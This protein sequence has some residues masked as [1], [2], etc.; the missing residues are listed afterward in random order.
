MD[1]EDNEYGENPVDDMTE[2]YDYHVN[3]HELPE[4]FDD[5]S[6]DDFIANLNDWDWLF[7]K[8][9]RNKTARPLG[10]AVSHYEISVPNY[11]KVILSGSKK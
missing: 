7:H 4:L 1:Y 2:D 3:T 5:E 9:Y 11:E 8:W 6:V 10:R